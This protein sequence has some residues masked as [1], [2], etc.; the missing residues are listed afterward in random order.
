MTNVCVLFAQKVRS[1]RECRH[2]RRI[3]S[4]LSDEVRK[5]EQIAKTNVCAKILRDRDTAVTRGR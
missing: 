5:Y 3:R 2:L 1:L 4:G